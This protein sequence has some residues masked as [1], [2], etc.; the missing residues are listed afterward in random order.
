[1][2]VALEVRFDMGCFAIVRNIII[3]IEVPMFGK[4]NARTEEVA[5]L[6]EQ[7]PA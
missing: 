2:N 7:N 5:V 1:M 6:Y 3:L 4:D